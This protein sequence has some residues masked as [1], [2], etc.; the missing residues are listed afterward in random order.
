[1]ITLDAKALL[2]EETVDAVFWPDASATGIL[3]TVGAAAQ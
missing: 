1:M 3:F 2:R